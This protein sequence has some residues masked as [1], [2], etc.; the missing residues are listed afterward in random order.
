MPNSN[1][2]EIAGLPLEIIMYNLPV[3]MTIVE[4]SSGRV[5]FANKMAV[6]LYGVNPIGLHSPGPFKFL[7]LN[8]E[9]FPIQELSAS[10]ALIDGET[11][12][13]QDL[14]I[15]QPN[16]K[17]VTITDTAIPIKK[18]GDE[19]VGALV[20]FEDI[21][22][23]K[24]M[25]EKL[26][27]YATTLEKLLEERTK[28]I[29]E[30]EQDY[31]ELYESFGEAF[32]ATDWEFNVIHWNKAAERV[33]TVKARDALGKKVY[34][35]LPEMMN[36]DVSPYFEALSK[37]KSARFMMNTVSR[38]THQP[39]VFEI[40]TY[41]STRGI[42]I[43]VE[44]KT[45]EELNKRLSA[46]GQTAGMIGHDIRNPL[47]AML[48]DIYL[49]KT[50]LANMPECGTKDEVVESLESIE[51]NIEYINK[52]VADLQDYSRPLKPN[53]QDTDL[54]HL[55]STV[56]QTIKI[57]ENIRISEN[58]RIIKPVKT[59]AEFLRRAL[60]NLIVN[61]IQAMPEGGKLSLRF[62]IVGNKVSI[63]VE[64]TGVGIPEE[65][66]LKIFVPMVTS[67]AKGQGLGL[68]V[69]KRLVEK[70]NGTISFVSEEGKGTKFIIE[71]PL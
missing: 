37:N 17:R 51:K 34:N 41:P 15:E 28:K 55:L 10:R 1:N 60:T 61:A 68:A 57:P 7:K 31:K 44:D 63:S 43:I 69:V 40:S 56:L 27:E 54:S 18:N 66:K 64:D 9:A 39:S 2:F 49:L 29:S 3:G 62:K 58:C 36:V 13:N 30:N 65:I 8:G 33:T 12:R 26:E 6:D 32:I 48:S 19:I 5:V 11:V 45:K 59:D 47:Q 21:T 24:R 35:V 71:L 38:E 14:I 67:K 20:I 52:I 42:I 16:S 46:I 53:F 23:R 25:Q 4:K 22:E 50:D 70:L